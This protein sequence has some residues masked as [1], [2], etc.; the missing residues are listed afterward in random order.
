MSKR[1][2]E[3]GWARDSSLSFEGGVDMG[4]PPSLID[5]N[6][7]ALLLNG[8]T[9]GG[10]IKPRPG[11]F[12]CP[13]LF[14]NADVQSFFGSGSSA[15]GFFQEANFYAGADMD[16]LLCSISGR[17]FRISLSPT[18]G[19][20]ITT[21]PFAI[22]ALGSAVPVSVLSTFNMSMS[23]P[24][25]TINGKPLTMLGFT[26]G[27][28]SITVRNDTA[29]NAGVG[30]ADS[31]T[32]A[33]PPLNS[34]FV[35]E[36]TPTAGVPL[37]AITT[38]ADFTIP[39][40][41]TPASLS[42]SDASSLSLQFPAIVIGG[43]TLT[44]TTTTPA[45]PGFMIPGVNEFLTL[46]VVS[47]V[48]LNLKYPELGIETATTVAGVSFPGSAG[49][50]FLLTP[51]SIHGMSMEQPGMKVNG[52][53]IMLLSVD[54]W[55]TTTTAD[56]TIDPVIGVPFSV[57]VTSTLGMP[58]GPATIGIGGYA[59]QLNSFDS[60]GLTVTVQNNDPANVG[61]T[62]YTGSQVAFEMTTGTVMVE[63]NV[64]AYAGTV[65]PPNA[66]LIFNLSV[67][68]ASIDAE[69]NTIEI[70]NRL[71]DNVGASIPSGAKI[72]YRMG[73]T[74]TTLTT[75]L[76]PADLDIPGV[77]SSVAVRVA[78]T[79]QIPPSLIGETI[80]IAGY[81]LVLKSIDGTTQITVI[82]MTSG[83]YDKDMPVG[84][85]V[86]F[87]TGG[88]TWLSASAGFTMPAVGSTVA[89]TLAST[90]QMTLNKLAIIVGGYPV[91]LTNI[92]GT[93]ITIRN[94]ASDNVGAFVAAGATV[95]FTTETYTLLVV[96]LVDNITVQVVNMLASQA[97]T[98]I[99]AAADVVVQVLDGNDPN[100]QLNWSLQAEKWW[101]LQDN[102]SLPVIFDGSKTFR[103][104]PA[105][106]QVPVGNVMCYAQGRLSVALPDRRSYRAGDGVFG[107]SG[108]AVENYLDSILYD[109]ETLFL[110]EGGDFQ[111]R[112]YGAPSNSGDIL[113]MFACAQSDTQLGQGPMMVGTPN[114]MFTVQL[115]FNRD[116]WK[117]M[118]DPLQ[119]A[120][121][122]AGPVGQRSVTLRNTDAWYR[123]LDGVRSYKIAQRQFNSDPGNTSMSNEIDPILDYDTKDLLEW[124]S[125]VDFDN[126][127][128]ETISPV[129]SASGVWHRGL[130]VLDFNLQDGLRKRFAPAWEGVWSGLRILKIITG[131]VNKTN[132]CFMFVLNNASQIELWELSTDNEY[133]GAWSPSGLYPPAPIKWVVET[134]GFNC[135]DSDWFKKLKTARISMPSISGKVKGVVTYKTDE[136]S[137]WQSWCEFTRC[138]KSGDCGP[139]SGC[140]PTSYLSQPR[141]P[142][143][144]PE[145]PDDFDPVSNRLFSTGYEFQLRLQLEGYGE[146][147]DIRIFSLDE[148]EM[149]GPDQP[150]EE[151]TVTPTPSGVPPG[152][153]V[154]V[155]GAILETGGGFIIGT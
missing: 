1:S 123:T 36:I 147:S 66:P 65:I 49:V 24:N 116:A 144:L 112:V 63:N 44:T 39:P 33:F 89:V 133:D 29:A 93:T 53:P 113:A 131:I 64:P 110:N 108:A 134:R 34:F 45:S 127:R 98:V 40:A 21:A 11:W 82:N 74:A 129:M 57:A 151:T 52:C 153:I 8:T 97:G 107:P 142:I 104:N 103:S 81:P 58:T 80:H 94:D 70:Q 19:T 155:G 102:Q 125:A 146:I 117:N 25:I 137:C 9:R 51:A 16:A 62:L 59:L 96:A 101:L 111:A 77:G 88:A 14:S 138:A 42:L 17:Q 31:S 120:N 43:N 91:T 148:P 6:Q 78:D 152:A 130:A 132:R 86:S 150:S 87:M 136:R 46:P 100:V 99:P 27:G 72:W 149:L 60:V 92:A 75:N 114:V 13:L 37:G 18:L 69:N 55:S 76:N 83:N 2:D 35:D 22:P 106:N 85:V 61:K 145:P 139:W 73:I 10:R 141:R 68:L 128:L 115:P 79:S 4:R 54:R 122:I 15:S 26:P 3:K 90:A 143:R 118:T 5:A 48:G 71:A 109:T 12:N 135:K 121:P 38:T 119:T 23:Y 105:K 126:R 84:S 47:T 95:S 20:T 50:P 154:G 32:V 67:T 28:T 124:G 41:N 30:V 140:F 7:L 56:Q